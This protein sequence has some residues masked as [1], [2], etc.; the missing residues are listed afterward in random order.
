[1]F[2]VS[3][4][5][6]RPF[7]PTKYW[8]VC[9]LDDDQA[10]NKGV[11]LLTRLVACI[12]SWK[13]GFNL[14]TVHV[15]LAINKVAIQVFLEVYFGFCRRYLQNHYHLNINFISSTSGRRVGNFKQTALFRSYKALHQRLCT[16]LVFKGIMGI[17]TI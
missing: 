3:L 13:S 8:P 7:L 12:L 9:L 6:S 14:G 1:V 2:R 11:P 10:K 5:V 16:L 15:R 4:T 17:R